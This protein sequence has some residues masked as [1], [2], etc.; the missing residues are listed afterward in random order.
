MIDVGASTG[1]KL[2]P[3]ADAGWRVFA[4]E[5]DPRNRVVLEHVFGDYPNVTIDPRAVSNKSAEKVIFYSSEV[6]LGISGLT[7]FHPTH[8]HTDVVDVTTLKEFLVQHQVHEVDVLKIDTEGHDYFVLKG[9]PWDLIRPEVVICEFDD[10][11][12]ESLGYTWQDLATYLKEKDYRVLVSEWK[13]ISEYGG[14]YQWDRIS[15]FP[16]K[17]NSPA[18][19]GN[20]VA[21][22]NEDVTKIILKK[23]YSF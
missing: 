14:T 15:E 17:L 7:P 2:A 1:L 8:T 23:F 9:F 4:F 13:P 16:S 20:I 22:D 10:G 11:K 6:S 18:S 21:V 3:F 5:P 12:T 19:W